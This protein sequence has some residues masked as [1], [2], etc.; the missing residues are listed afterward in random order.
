MMM[1]ADN[2]SGTFGTVPNS[3]NPAFW[4]VRPTLV[5][6]RQASTMLDAPNGFT[7][8]MP[9][10][11]LPRNERPNAFGGTG[12]DNTL[13]TAQRFQAMGQLPFGGGLPTQY[14]FVANTTGEENIHLNGG[15]ASQNLKL[16]KA[17][18]GAASA[19]YVTGNNATYTG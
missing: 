11:Q 2:V 10:T 14:K 18:R 16:A 7:G 15:V 9:V 6:S 17:S 12:W 4:Q 13:L 3:T 19:E 5:A 1:M 8:Q